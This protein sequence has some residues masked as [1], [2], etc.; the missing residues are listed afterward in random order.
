MRTVAD[1][2]VHGTTGEPPLE[3]FQRAEAAALRPLR[4]RPP[5]HWTRELTR[6]VHADGCV[7][8][9]TNHYS[10]PWRL[11][12]ETVTVRIVNQHLPCPRPG[13]RSPPHRHDRRRHQRSDE[14]GPLAA[15][16][17]HRANGGRWPRPGGGGR[18]ALEGW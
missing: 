13:S 12:G 11:I 1:V 9:D 14:R 16:P 18:E 15:W 3:R 5:F 8:V 2:R 10:V 7:E 4:D 6:Q 17:A